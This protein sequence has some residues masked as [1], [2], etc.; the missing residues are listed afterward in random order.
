MLVLYSVS[1]ISI[2]RGERDMFKV[3]LKIVSG[4]NRLYQRIITP[5]THQS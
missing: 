5:P 2:D 3:V 1:Y 4:H